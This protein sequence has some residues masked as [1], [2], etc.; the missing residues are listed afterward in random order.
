MCN[1]TSIRIFYPETTK[2]VFLDNY[3]FFSTVEKIIRNAV[4]SFLSYIFT[5]CYIRSIHFHLCS[6]IEIVILETLL[7]QS[8]FRLIKIFSYH[9]YIEN[10]IYHKN[11][12]LFIVILLHYVKKKQIE[13]TIEKSNIRMK[14][15]SV[16][17][18]DINKVL[19]QCIDLYEPHVISNFSIEHH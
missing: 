5:V 14:I 8:D 3:Y 1:I 9:G 11:R 15:K 17:T 6:F 13:N 10:K 2:Y 16:I 12:V 19:N 4:Q 18:N 7:S